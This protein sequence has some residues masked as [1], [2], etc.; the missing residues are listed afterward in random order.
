MKRADLLGHNIKKYRERMGL[1]QGELAEKLFVS[2]QAVSA[3]ERSQ[4]TPDLDNIIRLS[5]LF[6]VSVDTLLRNTDEPFFVGVDGGGI[7]TEF[8]LFLPDGTV[9]KRVLSAGSNPNNIGEE[10]CLRILTEGLEKLLSGARPLGI[11][12]GIAGAGVGRWRTILASTLKERLHLDVMVD[13]YAANVLSLGHDPDNTATILCGTSSCVFVRKG[14]AMH[15][16]GGWGQLFDE[17]GSAY[18]V[19]KDAVR[20]TLSV[21]DGLEQ[22][23]LLSEAVEKELGCGIWEGLAAIYEKGR[24]YIASLAHIVLAAADKGD[25]A[26][27]AILRKNAKR[28]GLLL[29]TARQRYGAGEEFVQAGGFFQ[30][31][32]Y[33]QMVEAESGCK[34]VD[35]GLPPVYGAC[36]EALRRTGREIPP[37]FREKFRESYGKL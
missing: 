8:C 2:F 32:R 4:S 36:V 20:H 26:A 10:G 7:K 5:D 14:D 21:L 3:W 30:N 24:A 29:R 27:D 9:K 34:L 17:A 37:T 18:D 6:S 16:L 25:A 12:L 1:T 35:P 13:T 15:R 11:F 23:S 22:P 19:G 28:L 33:C 31:A